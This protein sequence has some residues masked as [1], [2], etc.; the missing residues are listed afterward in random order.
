MAVKT[1]QNYMAL[2]RRYGWTPT[3]DGLKAFARGDHKN[4]LIKKAAPDCNRK[5]AQ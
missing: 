2:C 1:L 5:A 4:L 3:F